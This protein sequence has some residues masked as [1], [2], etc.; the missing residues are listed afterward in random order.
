MSP[1]RT[2]HRSRPDLFSLHDVIDSL[3]NSLREVV[4]LNHRK[5]LTFDEMERATSDIRDGLASQYE[6]S[7]SRIRARL[8]ETRDQ[9]RCDHIRPG[10]AASAAQAA[11]SSAASDVCEQAGPRDSRTAVRR[12]SRSPVTAHRAH[13]GRVDPKRQPRVLRPGGYANRA[14]GAAGRSAFQ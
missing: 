11:Q 9:E 1:N 4:L 8:V 5:E 13:G 6:R 3:T 12:S 2:A 14:R 7:T 10:K